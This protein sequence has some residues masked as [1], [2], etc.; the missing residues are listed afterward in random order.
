MKHIKKTQEKNAKCSRPVSVP[1]FNKY[2]KTL[3]NERELTME[4]NNIVELTKQNDTNLRRVE[5]AAEDLD[6]C[7]INSPLG[8]KEYILGLAPTTSLQYQ[9][10]KMIIDEKVENIVLFAS[11]EDIKNEK[12]A[13]YWP[14]HCSNKSVSYSDG[15]SKIKITILADKRS[16]S[17][18]MHHFKI[19]QASTVVKTRFWHFTN[20]DKRGTSRHLDSFLLFLQGLQ[21]IER[22]LQHPILV[23]SICGLNASTDLFILLDICIRQAKQDGVVDMCYQVRKLRTQQPNCIATVEEYL[24]AHQ[25][26]DKYF[27]L[28]SYAY[29]YDHNPIIY[30]ANK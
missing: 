9:F 14:D 28:P 15:C 19:E 13:K 1:N 26:L 10:W 3:A 24:F 12:F 18:D 20:C 29:V 4:Y 30:F 23:H 25:Y 5:T 2:V 11:M 17:Y 27:S 7:Y 21:F 8:D 22:S 16:S 6:A